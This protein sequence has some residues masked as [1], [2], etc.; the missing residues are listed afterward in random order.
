MESFIDYLK[1]YQYLTLLIYL[2]SRYILEWIVISTLT[3][4]NA[5]FYCRYFQMH[6]IIMH[7]IIATKTPVPHNVSPEWFLMKSYRTKFAVDVIWYSR[8]SVSAAHVLKSERWVERSSFFR[9]W[10][11]FELRSIFSERTNS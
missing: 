6:P 4:Y 1:K 2:R 7:S 10:A 3:Q 11:R 9:R 5:I 8:P